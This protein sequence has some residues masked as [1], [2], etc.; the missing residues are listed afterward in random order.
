MA[1][2]ASLGL[3]RYWVCF[4]PDD[5]PDRDSSFSA[6]REM[7]LS[8]SQTNPSYLVQ[9]WTAIPRAEWQEARYPSAPRRSF[10]HT[11]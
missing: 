6:F 4:R 10:L 11:A 3:S 7:D 9:S 8:R 2:R 1:P 5:V